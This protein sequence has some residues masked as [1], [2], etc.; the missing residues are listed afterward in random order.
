M[1]VLEKEVDTVVAE[2]TL[3]IAVVGSLFA[4]D[5]QISFMHFFLPFGLALVCMLPCLP[6]ILSK[7]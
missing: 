7:I 4:R 2:N 6:T 5:V 1:K 3:S